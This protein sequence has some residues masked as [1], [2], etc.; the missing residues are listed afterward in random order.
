MIVNPD[1]DLILDFVIDSFLT[2]ERL[3]M[4]KLIIELFFKKTI[5]LCYD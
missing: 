5:R 3:L 1:L 4:S 2:A